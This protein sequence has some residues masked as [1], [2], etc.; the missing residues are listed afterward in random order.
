M[1]ALLSPL[2]LLF[3]LIA[4]Q[5]LYLSAQSFKPCTGGFS[6]QFECD[7][8][9]L[10]ARIEGSDIHA[11][12]PALNDVWGFINLNDNK[13]YAVIGLVNGTAV[14][15]ISDPNIPVVTGFVDGMLSI[16]RDVKVYQ[17]FDEANNRY[18]AYAY[19]TTEAGQGLQIIDLADLPNGISLAATIND[20]SSAHNI[21]I[22]NI[23]YSTGI[24][25]ENFTPY[26]YVVGSNLDDGAFRVYDLTDPLI[27]SL[28]NTAP[29]GSNYIHDVTTF[30]IT[31]SRTD[32]CENSNNP[33]E[34]LVDFSE[35]SVGIWDMT[36]PL[37]PFL[38]SR[39]SYQNVGYTHSGW[40]SEDKL[41][42]FV[43]DELD[44]VNTGTN[45]LLRT[46]DISDLSAP[47]ISNVYSGPTLAIDHNGFTVGDR[48]YMSNYRRGLTVL[49]VSNP[50]QLTEAGFF[51]TYPV[52][53]ANTAT[54][55]GAWGVFP[56]FPSGNILI[57]DSSNGLFIVKQAANVAPPAPPPAPTMGGGGTVGI[58]LLLLGL[59]LHL[60]F[61]FITR[62]SSTI[63]IV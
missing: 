4:L 15:D 28:L 35:D 56:F 54:F 11:S 40:W 59:L 61:L 20:F 13:E 1:K 62:K 48:Y 14:I 38:I 24:A 2:K 27:P 36:N 47:F 26:I 17:F 12:S 49:D 10:Q 42:I 9:G 50:N 60:R 5:S 21:Y 57:S 46:L 19:V 44:E 41:F 29:A 63:S 18:Q 8:L 32:Q 30:T 33:C 22:A 16:W 52:P 25:V 6:A 45:T 58:T 39:T 43:Q 53:A 7:G 37:N 23:D 51:D 34:I 31:D 3:T 55:D